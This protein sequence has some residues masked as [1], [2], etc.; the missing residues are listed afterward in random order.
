MS[1]LVKICGLST[2]ESLD[3]ALICGG[4]DIGVMSAIGKSR[5]RNSYQFPLIGIAPEGIVTWPEGPRNTSAPFLPGNERE[6]LESHHSH[7]ILVPGSQFGDE[8]PAAPT[9][10][11]DC[12]AA[13]RKSHRVAYS[14]WLSTKI[15]ARPTTEIMVSS[16]DQ[17][18]NVAGVSVPT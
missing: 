4:T 12:G 7:F 16:T 5:S 8:F 17:V 14:T 10:S 6:Q 1:L 15:S 3:A 2:P 9:R 11:T 13:G 18:R